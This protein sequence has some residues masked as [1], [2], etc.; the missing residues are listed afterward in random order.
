M[1]SAIVNF[2]YFMT[3]IVAIVLILTVVVMANAEVF[4]ME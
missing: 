3:L 2:I 4:N 1:K